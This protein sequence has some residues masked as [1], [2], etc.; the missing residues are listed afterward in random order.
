MSNEHK[1]EGREV[2]AIH[3]PDGA[4]GSIRILRSGSNRQFR[5]TADKS[6]HWILELQAGIEMRRHNVRFIESIIWIED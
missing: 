6:G 5:F 1:N 3:W 2:S 4:D